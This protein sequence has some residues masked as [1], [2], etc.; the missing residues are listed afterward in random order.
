MSW[1]SK[2]E[3]E[4]PEDIAYCLMGL[5][6]I[7]M[8][9]LHGEGSKAFLRL[10]EEILKISDDES[11]S[12]WAPKPDCFQPLLAESP[13]F[14]QYSGEIEP[15]LFGPDRPA[16]SLTNKGLRMEPLCVIDDIGNLAIQLNCRIEYSND[17]LIVT[18]TKLDDNKYWRCG[19][20]PLDF[21]VEGAKQPGAN[22][23][24]SGAMRDQSQILENCSNMA[25]RTL[26]YRNQSAVPWTLQITGPIDEE[27]I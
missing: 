26:K 14:Y 15:F 25:N 7:N 18:L 9:L 17:P 23:A 12:A 11:L 4:R 5:F 3:T 20:P 13:S 21:L 6:G 16:Y 27:W 24:N 10:Q 19:Q 22:D 8:P 1:A 2:R